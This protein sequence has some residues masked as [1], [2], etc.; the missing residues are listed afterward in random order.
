MVEGQNCLLLLVSRV[1]EIA[2]CANTV[3]QYYFKS[4]W[5]RGDCHD[6]E[7]TNKYIGQSNFEQERVRQNMLRGL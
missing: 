2:S 5:D 7:E 6:T 4:R 1:W 3:T